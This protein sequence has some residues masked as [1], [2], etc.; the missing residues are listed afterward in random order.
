MR[1]TKWTGLYT[2]ECARVC[3]RATPRER[4]QNVHLP[5]C[6]GRIN[7][8][9]SHRHPYEILTLRRLSDLFCQRKRFRVPARNKRSPSHSVSLLF[10]PLLFLPLSPTHSL[11]LPPSR[12]CGWVRVIITSV[13]SMSTTDDDTVE[14][15]L[16]LE[17]FTPFGGVLVHRV[18]L[19]ISFS[20]EP[21]H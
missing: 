9:V 7:S 1:T 4:T 17:L 8:T 18:G 10:V 20:A 3:A 15:I 2:S 5:R 21:R 14:R 19:I 13:E 6:G 11:S 16:V 12:P